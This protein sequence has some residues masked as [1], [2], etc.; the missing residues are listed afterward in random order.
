MLRDID[1]GRDKQVAAVLSVIA[2]VA[3][4]VLA[5]QGV[6][7]DLGHAALH[8]L[9]ERLNE[10][11]HAMPHV[12]SARPN[13]GMQTDLD[14]DGDGRLRGPGDAQ[15]FGFFSGANGIA[16][17]SRYPIL[18]GAV[19]DYSATLWADVPDALT[20]VHPDGSPF[21]TAKAWAT[22]RLSSTAH[23]IVP[24]DLDGKHLDILTFQAGPPV[25]DGPED[26]NGKRNHD[27]IALAQRMLDDAGGAFVIAAGANLDPFDS[28]GLHSAIRALLADPRLTDPQPESPGGASAPDEGH[29]GPNAQDTVDWPRVGRLRVDYVL[30]SATLKVIGSGVFWPEGDARVT[31]ASRHRLVWV[32]VELP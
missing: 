20:P 14:L 17:L 21:P 10:A 16:L 22:Q 4:D 19:R 6:D 11:G 24:V 15:G 31:D 32:D 30:P 13:A 2:E 28:D 9:A 25:F 12:F 29:S 1:S 7:W 8:R 27:E 5:L 3:P 26:R 23:W 18:D